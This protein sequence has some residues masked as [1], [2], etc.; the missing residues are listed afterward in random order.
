V[1]DCLKQEFVTFW[2]IPK[3]VIHCDCQQN[4][5]KLE[6]GVYEIP[7]LLLYSDYDE[8]AWAFLKLYEAM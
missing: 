3:C 5:L 4:L 2:E 1:S 6:G 7:K 8:R